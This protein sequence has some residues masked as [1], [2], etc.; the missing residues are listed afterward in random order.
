MTATRTF[1]HDDVEESYRRDGYAV[2]T[3]FQPDQAEEVASKL[4]DLV[5]VRTDTFAATLY[6][7]DIT[8]RTSV[9]ERLL[10]IFAAALA[11]HLH[12]RRCFVANLL[13]KPPGPG[14]AL[15]VHRDWTFVDET[16][17]SSA[18]AWCALSEV[19]EANG[20]LVV[21][22]GSHLVAPDLRGSPKLPS[23]LDGHEAEI[24]AAGGRPLA[25]R[26]G[27]A[28]IYD[29]RTVHWSGPNSSQSDRIAVGVGIVPSDVELWHYHVDPAGVVSRYAVPDDFLRDL[30]IGSP[31]PRHHGVETLGPST[32]RPADDADLE[33]LT[34][35]APR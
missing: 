21:L 20:T 30:A 9:D 11:P 16:Q 23:P 18:T 17:T 6:D 24:L 10:P 7:G 26:A 1:V 25:L 28:A 12:R 29:H 19:D 27:Q 34:R 8:Y 13:V 14:T 32:A 22:P 31:P 15:G 4:A 33:F 35:P 3:V 5:R 2:V